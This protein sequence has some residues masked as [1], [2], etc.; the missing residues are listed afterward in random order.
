MLSLSKISSASGCDYYLELAREDY[1]LNGGEPRSVVRT[2]T[3]T[4]WPQGGRRRRG[5]DP[6]DPLRRVPPG[7]RREARPEP[8][9]PQSDP[10]WDMT[11]SMPKS[12]SVLWSQTTQENRQTLQRIH[13]EA[14]KAALAYAQ[15]V[16]G[17]TR[18]GKG[19]T[20]LT[21]LTCSLRSSSTAPAEPSTRTCTAT[22]S[23]RTSVS[24]PTAPPAPFIRRPSTTTRWPLGPCTGWW[25][26]M[27]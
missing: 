17:H 22:L 10:G 19:A 27:D 18:R 2:G 1:Y 24:G 5:Q 15:E 20:R 11:F 23:S 21:G 9:F 26:P 3:G 25:R 6:Q 4:F 8:R 12:A 16:A 7:H 14:V 13:E